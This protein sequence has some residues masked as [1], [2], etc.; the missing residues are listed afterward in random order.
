MGMWNKE[1][2]PICEKE[3]GAL[4]KSGV[5]KE[6][7]YICRNCF[8]KLTSS[9]VGTFKIKD[10]SADELKQIIN[11]DSIT[12]IQ[13]RKNISY[14]MKSSSGLY[15]FCV[16]SGYG[17]GMT[18]SWGEKHFQLVVDNLK[19]DEDVIFAFIGLHN[20]VSA[21]KHD[22]NYAYVLTNKRFI[23]AQK[24]LVGETFQTVSLDN[25]NDITFDSGMM[26]GILTVDTFK[27]KF[28]IA[29]DK[30]S[31]KNI[32]NR[33]HDE[34]DK[35]N[36][37]SKSSISNAQV[38]NADEIKKYKDLLDMGAISQ[39]EFDAKKKELLNL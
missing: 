37:I 4:G 39:E 10:L 30:Y 31:A 7:S 25:I 29:L 36:R 2:C 8:F 35:L 3:T 23:M 27:E 21:T 12:N 22:S 26:F 19:S 38:S 32:S 18:K 33:L 20:Y 13:E 6:N 16:D 14:D 34:L 17:Q 28:N 1:Q 15:Q 24:K 9:G 5:K 11:G